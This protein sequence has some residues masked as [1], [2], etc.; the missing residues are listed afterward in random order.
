LG[1]VVM[2]RD[3]KEL[4]TKMQK[5]FRNN[6]ATLSKEMQEMLMDDLVTAFQSRISVLSRVQE[7]RGFEL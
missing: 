1:Q 7:K 5:V 4:K 2:L 6:V 3:R